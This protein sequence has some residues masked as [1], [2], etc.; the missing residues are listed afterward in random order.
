MRFYPQEV[1]IPV[2]EM[3]LHRYTSA[4]VPLEENQIGPKIAVSDSGVITFPAYLG[5]APEEFYLVAWH[6]GLAMWHSAPFM[7]FKGDAAT[8][9]LPL[10]GTFL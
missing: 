5:D 2:D 8:F 7:L 4:S 1:T 9:E 10:R 3:S 6:K